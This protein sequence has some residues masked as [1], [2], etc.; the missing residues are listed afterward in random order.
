ME[1]LDHIGIAVN[2]IDESNKL[3]SR[4]L[5]KDNF[6]TEIVDSEGVITS[7]FE[8]GDSKIELVAA[9]DET[10]PIA[11]FIKKKKQGIH[12]IALYVS[13]ILI[14]M[15]RLKKEGIGLLNDVPKKGADNKLICFLDPKDTNGVLIEICQKS[16]C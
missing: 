13:D 8:I 15:E 11:K 14:E 10:S 2:D 12:H 3:F 6:E 9:L 7:S 16:T 1:R 4:I 5:G